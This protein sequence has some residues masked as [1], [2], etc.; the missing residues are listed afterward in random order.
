M[1]KVRCV[2]WVAFI[3]SLTVFDVSQRP[4][5]VLYVISCNCR[6]SMEQS[7]YQRHC[8]NFSTVFSRWQSIVMSMSVCVSVCLWAY[9]SNHM[10]DLYRIFN[11]CCLPPWLG[12]PPAGWRNRRSSRRGSLHHWQCI[13]RHSIWDPYKYGWRLW[14]VQGTMCYMGCRS[15][16]GR[17][18]FRGLFGPFK[19]IGN[20]CCSGRYRIRYKRAHS[21]ANNVM[22]QKGSL[23]MPGKRK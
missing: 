10:G 8:I 3:L 12:R 23:S 2:V 21:I 13:V 6:A 18:N 16:K 15:P 20:L 11:A 14:S 1:E 17:R 5:V 9:L 4:T 22:R 19:S 7:S